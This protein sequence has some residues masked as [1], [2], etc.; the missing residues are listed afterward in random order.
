[1]T[2]RRRALLSAAGALGCIGASPSIRAAAPR[3]VAV[4]GA[5]IIGTSIAYH[6]ARYGARVTI[7][8]Q[9]SPAAGTSRNSFAW[10]NAFNKLPQPYFLLNFL[11]VLGWRRLQ[12]EIGPSL[13]IQ[14]GGGVAWHGTQPD[15]LAEMR[16][17]LSRLQGWGYPIQ[18][19]GAK[20][21][22]DLL[23]G[24]RAGAVGGAWH[25]QIDGTLDPVETVGALMAAAQRQGVTL[26]DS[27]NVTG[28][29]QAEGKITGVET[30]SGPIAADAIVLAMGNDTPP[31]AALAGIPLPLKPS[32]GV[33]AH[34]KPIAPFFH[35]VIMPPGCDIK[36][37]PDGRI[38]TGSNFGDSGTLRAS[39]EVGRQ[40]LAK[41]TSYFPEM[42]AP[43]LD[44]MTLG[45]RVL[46]ADGLPVVGAGSRFGNVHVAAMHSGMTLAP[47]IGQ[48]VALEVL[49][50]VRTPYLADFRPARFS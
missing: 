23:P 37:N 41:V 20:E 36:Q 42:P 31:L 46:P 38:V 27:V 6:L 4:V 30:T 28:F 8:E 50:G 26:R 47:I 1:M 5:G 43:E 13:R 35:R 45:F 33:L 9:A 16:A 21:F 11:G 48:L 14:W 19:I 22:R 39:P 10:L 40:F 24:V 12:Q 17:T 29:R 2:I 32:R 7:L 34:S 18:E 25:S 44:F 3:H 15:E 49:D